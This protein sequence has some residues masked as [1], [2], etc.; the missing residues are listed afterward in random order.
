[1][2]TRPLTDI[3]LARRDFI[4]ARN[5]EERNLMLAR[6]VARKAVALV[7]H[8]RNRRT[9]PDHSY[10]MAGHSMAVHYREPVGK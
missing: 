9:G 4:R 8:A 10:K 7:E 5:R 3:E 1:M 2:T 6:Q